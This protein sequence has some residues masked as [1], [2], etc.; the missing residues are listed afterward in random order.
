MSANIW[1][2]IAGIITAIVKSI[3]GT[4]KASKTTVETPKG[5]VEITDGKDE[6]ERRDDL[7]I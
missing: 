1:T 4:N 6:E 3:F 5:E 7:G 2:T